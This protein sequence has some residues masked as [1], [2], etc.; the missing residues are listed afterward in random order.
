MT[1]IAFRVETLEGA[2]IAGARIRILD[3]TGGDATSLL[4]NQSPAYTNH[5]G[6]IHRDLVMPGPLPLGDYGIQVSAPGYALWTN[7]QTAWRGIADFTITLFAQAVDF[8]VE[9][10]GGIRSGMA[11]I[12]YRAELSAADLPEFP[13][14]ITTVTA[15]GKDSIILSPIEPETGTAQVDIRSRVHLGVRPA[16]VPDDKWLVRDTEFGTL[17]DV[18]FAL[19]TLSA[20]QP[21]ADTL[22]PVW[23]CQL[24]PIDETG[25]VEGSVGLEGLLKFFTHVRRSGVAVMPRFSGHYADVLLFLSQWAP[26]DLTLEAWSEDESLLLL[27]ESFTRPSGEGFYRLRLPPV[28]DARFVL[29]LS[30]PD[31]P[32]TENLLVETLR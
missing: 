1:Y 16:L 27:E 24:Y 31:G 28:G 11:P 3:S 10:P 7:A 8:A 22:S 18:S 32:I 15:Y 25:N 26:A 9:G 21:L 30:G 6:V 12:V 13:Q 2:P 14:L 17:A 20:D 19:Q 23:V 4:L 5:E 29:R